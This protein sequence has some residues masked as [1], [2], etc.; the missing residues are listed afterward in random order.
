MYSQIQLFQYKLFQY[1]DTVSFS[2]LLI[3]IETSVNQQSMYCFFL[4]SLEV[5]VSNPKKLW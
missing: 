1:L 2:D 5:D 4:V 3:I